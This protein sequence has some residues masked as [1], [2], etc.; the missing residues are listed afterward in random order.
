VGVLLGHM[1]CLQ[2]SNCFRIVEEGINNYHLL[3]EFVQVGSRVRQVSCSVPTVKT[4]LDCVN[5][6][7]TDVANWADKTGG[8]VKASHRLIM[9][10]TESPHIATLSKVIWVRG[11]EVLVHRV[12]NVGR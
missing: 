4:C 3:L 6:G 1:F 5:L 10:G 2:L 12:G 9:F 8:I 11:M 7:P